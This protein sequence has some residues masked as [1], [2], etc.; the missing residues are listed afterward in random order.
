MK[1]VYH[2]HF[3]LSHWHQT[4]CQWCHSAN[5]ISRVQALNLIPDLCYVASVHTVSYS[6]CILLVKLNYG[7]TYGSGVL[8]NS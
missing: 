7:D 3:F 5:F 4:R 2:L 8:G 1:Y 6:F